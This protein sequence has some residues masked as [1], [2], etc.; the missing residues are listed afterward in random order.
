MHPSEAPRA[1]T[2]VLAGL[3]LAGAGLRS[4][5]R[6]PR[7]LALGMVPGAAVAAVMGIAL[8]IL[9]AHLDR[10]GAALAD[11][12]GAE[13]GW[14]HGLVAV[15]AGAAVL[16][17]SAVVAVA[18]FTSLTLAI[19]QPFFEAISRRTDQAAGG[20][21]GD[22]PDERWTAGLA[23]AVR[24]GA[25]TLAISLGLSVALVLVGLVPVA[26]SGVAFAAGAILGGRLLAIELTAYPLARRGIVDRRARVA[27]LRPCRVRA[28]T[29]GAVVFLVFLLPLG[30]VLAMPAAV[31]GATLLARQ[32]A[33]RQ[34]VPA[35]PSASSA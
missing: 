6:E 23:R 27:A 24:E 22:V 4:W 14:W 20:F 31:A 33:E 10:V 25:H 12:V 34:A 11:A 5:A 3:R 18:L 35:P 21:D 2:E 15:T 7:L 8:G 13:A 17:G 32:V 29:F 30:A 16:V 19:G 1:A 9:A 26:G 28:T